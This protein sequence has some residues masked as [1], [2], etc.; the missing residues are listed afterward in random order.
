VLEIELPPV[1]T[2]VEAAAA[3]Y[4]RHR[5][6][7]RVRSGLWRRLAA[8][9]YCTAEQWDAA[10]RPER[11]LLRG[12]AVQRRWPGS[13]LS[14]LTAAAAWRWPLPLDEVLRCG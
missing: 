1:F 11:Y 8:G 9:V 3:G 6:A 12:A 2:R 10:T 4:G 13:V 7:S 5:V 14:H